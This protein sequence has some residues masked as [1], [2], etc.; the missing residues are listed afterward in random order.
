MH[1]RLHSPQASGDTPVSTSHLAEGASGL[2]D[3]HS[4]SWPLCG[5]WKPTLWSSL[6]CCKCFIE[7][8]SLQPREELFNR[9]MV[10]QACNFSTQDGSQCKPVDATMSQKRKFRLTLFLL[11]YS[12]LIRWDE[13]WVGAGKRSLDAVEPPL[14]NMRLLFS[15]YSLNSYYMKQS[16]P[17]CT[18][19]LPIQSC[20]IAY[21]SC[22]PFTAS[23]R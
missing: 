13:H 23:M 5:F 7:K 16:S 10:V 8:P 4:C 19:L 21:H 9:G 22:S 6:M 18:L 12:E 20:Q 2:W 15:R 3:K 14:K 17:N 11:I 1:A